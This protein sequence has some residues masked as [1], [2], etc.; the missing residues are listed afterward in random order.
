MRKE[1]SFIILP[2][3]KSLNIIPEKK[4]FWEAQWYARNK[5]RKKSL[6]KETENGFVPFD[7]YEVP[8]T[9]AY[10]LSFLTNFKLSYID[11]ST[12]IDSHNELMENKVVKKIKN[13]NYSFFFFSP[14]TNNYL[15]AKSI[16][17]IIKN[18]NQ[19]SI[20]I[21]GGPHATALPLEV[22]RDG[23]DFVVKGHGDD[24][25]LEFNMCSDFS[26]IKL[27]PNVCYLE[28]NNLKCS[29]SIRKKDF[30]KTPPISYN[31]LPDKYKETYYTRLFTIFGCP[32]KCNFCSNILWNNMGALFKNLKIIEMELDEIIRNIK[33]EEIY[34]NDETFT[35]NKEHA[36]KVSDLLF[37]K[38]VKWGCETRVDQINLELIEY[39]AKNGCK[40]ID[41]GIESF[42]FNV[43]KIANKRIT[44]EEIEIA[45]RMTSSSGIRTHA[46]IM[47]GLPG[48]TLESALF[49]IKKT[50]ELILNGLINT[51]DYFVL[52]PYPGTPIFNNPDKY[53][54]KILSKDWSKYREDELPVFEYEHFSHQEIFETWILGLKKFSDAMFKGNKGVNI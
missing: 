40:E 37:K 21:I 17:K 38:N 19:N 29:H 11:L 7:Q 34:V 14:F 51:V 2:R 4:K 36:R 54:I 31:L 5:F 9:A 25:L 32:F 44:I 6:L 24:F 33:F 16:L 52:V 39:F 49:T 43:L 41:F 35:I 20:C 13:K 10:I 18:Y 3:V 47:I 26:K 22:L 15:I 48:E 45:L 42:D 50:E 53:K 8:Y 23:F 28:N 46:N 27:L 30:I 12:Y 1:V